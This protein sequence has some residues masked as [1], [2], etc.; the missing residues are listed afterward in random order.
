MHSTPPQPLRAGVA[1]LP[2]CEG[3]EKHPERHIYCVPAAFGKAFPISTISPGQKDWLSLLKKNSN[4]E[5]NSF[6]L[7][8]TAGHPKGC[9]KSVEL[10]GTYTILVSN[11]VDWE[12][13]KSP[14]LSSVTWR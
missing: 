13:A 10:T 1:S 2:Q 7:K 14:Q 8:D 12:L 11:W 9:F 5:T 6:I 4:L 3:R